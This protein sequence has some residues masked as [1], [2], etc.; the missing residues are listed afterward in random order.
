MVLSVD[1]WTKNG[2]NSIVSRGKTMGKNEMFVIMPS[3]NDMNA[4]EKEN[5]D[6]LSRFFHRN[7][8]SS[9][10][11]CVVHASRGGLG[12]FLNN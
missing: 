12:W 10:A 9:N 8:E 5:H 7:N 1:A 4:I 6:K 2:T 11:V 3:V